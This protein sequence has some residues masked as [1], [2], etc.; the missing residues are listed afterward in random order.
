MDINH[1]IN[2][3]YKVK[4]IMDINHKIKGIY[5]TSIQINTEDEF[6]K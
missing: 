1:K 6:I 2:R 4:E 5:K 3:I